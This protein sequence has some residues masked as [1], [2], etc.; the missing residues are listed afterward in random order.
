MKKEPDTNMRQDEQEKLS[1][2]IEKARKILETK[3][4]PDENL[5]LG[6]LE[7]LKKYRIDT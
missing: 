2:V 1:A 5:S 4:S 6:T 3:K 7:Y